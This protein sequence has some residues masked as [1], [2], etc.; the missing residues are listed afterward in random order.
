VT[1]VPG[2]IILLNGTS[3]SGKTAIAREL[4]DVLDRPWF[5]LAA[6]MFGA[7]RSV[8]RTAELDE[9]AWT[10]VFRRTRAGFHRAVAGMAAAGN[11]VVMDNV[12]TEA[13]RL[14]DCLQVLA[15]YDVIFVGVH[16]DAAELTRREQARGDRVPGQAAKQLGLVHV[17]GRYDL[18]VDTTRRSARDCAE[19][20]R[21]FAATHHGTA[22]DHLRTQQPTQGLR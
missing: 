2:R 22:F 16:C 13:W 8:S 3:S 4:L 6:D 18:E 17:H 5:H 19:Q 12:L 21:D 20:I 11:D 9:D 15:P 14:P 10:E 7:M 1:V